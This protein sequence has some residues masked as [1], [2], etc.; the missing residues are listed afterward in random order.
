MQS[1]CLVKYTT[2]SLYIRT[3]VVHTYQRH[4]SSTNPRTIPCYGA[5]PAGHKEDRSSLPEVTKEASTSS[6]PRGPCPGTRRFCLQT[7]CAAWL[8]QKTA[9]AKLNSP[10]RGAA[11]SPFFA[12]TNR[13]SDIIYLRFVI[14][15]LTRPIGVSRIFSYKNWKHTHTHTHTHTHPHTAY[16]TYMTEKIEVINAISVSILPMIEKSWRL[17]CQP[18]CYAFQRYFG[19]NKVDPVSRVARILH[20]SL[21]VRMFLTYVTSLGDGQAATAAT[22]APTPSP[23]PG[24]PPGPPST[25]PYRPNGPEG[26]SA[27]TFTALLSQRPLNRTSHTFPPD[28]N[29]ASFRLRDRSSRFVD[30]SCRQ[31]DLEDERTASFVSYAPGVIPGVC[32]SD[33]WI[34]ASRRRRETPGTERHHEGYFTRIGDKAHIVFALPVH[35]FFLIRINGG[36]MDPLSYD[37]RKREEQWREKENGGGAFSTIRGRSKTRLQRVSTCGA[38]RIVFSDATSRHPILELI[39]STLTAFI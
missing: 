18:R 24:P 16:W 12:L 4:S 28:A 2:R 1:S 36:L 7:I 39:P 26:P 14:P 11:N 15:S 8:P 22:P 38:N 32:P 27:P 9:A 23:G 17:N 20:G 33:F 19:V 30:K 5:I 21:D 37:R 10:Q 35:F 34:G 13:Y 25:G 6:S 3:L 31:I 29:N